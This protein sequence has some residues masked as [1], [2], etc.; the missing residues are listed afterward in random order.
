MWR[1]VEYTSGRQDLAEASLLD[2]EESQL[3]RGCEESA[4]LR[5]LCTP[6]RSGKPRQIISKDQLRSSSLLA[7]WRNTAGIGG[8]V[9][10]S[11]CIIFFKT[12]PMKGIQQSLSSG[13]E[14][15]AYEA[16][17][18]RVDKNHTQYAV[19][20]I[21]W[22]VSGQDDAHRVCL[23]VPY[24][25]TYDGAPVQ[26]WQCNG[27]DMQKFIYPYAYGQIRLYV[28]PQ[29]CLNAPNETISFLHLKECDDEP[30]TGTWP[31]KFILPREPVIHGLGA[32]RLWNL[33]ADPEQT[34]G[35]TQ[36]LKIMTKKMN[37]THLRE[38]KY[39]LQGY[40]TLNNLKN[41]SA[42]NV[43]DLEHNLIKMD[44][45][46]FNQKNKSNPA[47]D[48]SHMA[49]VAWG[50]GGV[51]DDVK[52]VKP[53]MLWKI[54]GD[55]PTYNITLKPDGLKGQY[56]YLSEFWIE[57]KEQK[58]RIDDLYTKFGVKEFQFYLAFEGFSHPPVNRNREV[59]DTWRCKVGPTASYRPVHKK[60][61]MK[62]TEYIRSISGRSWLYL[63]AQGADPTG[64][65]SHLMDG[66][67]KIDQTNV[68]N[69]MAKKL[70]QLYND[71]NEASKSESEYARSCGCMMQSKL[72][73]EGDLKG[74]EDF[75]SMV[76]INSAWAIRIVDQWA[77]FANK[78]GFNGIHW[79]TEG[80]L[81]DPE[82]HAAHTD[83]AGFLKTAVP[84]LQKYNLT[85]TLNF[86]DGY[87]W[88]PRLLLGSW[89][90]IAFKYWEVR[91]DPHDSNFEKH[92]TDD[93]ALDPYGGFVWVCYPGWTQYHCCAHNERQ[94]ADN[95]GKWPIDLGIDRWQ[96][97]TRY[98]GSYLFVGDGKRHVQGPFLPDASFMM[99]KDIK[100]IQAKVGLVEHKLPP[101]ED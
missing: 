20:T 7:T 69:R 37:Y 66:F 93:H 29:W 55:V 3:S 83:I 65:G 31:Q 94:N 40:G 41:E 30:T 101:D 61:I 72:M 51:S 84:Y 64:H 92:L 33:T 68:T 46:S 88:D 91:T 48:R 67:K 19:G 1:N 79:D 23:D 52:L 10:L 99:E 82:D 11:F 15:E 44:H 100:K 74:V 27:K 63:H 81:G 22:A 24:G 87:G 16:T 98:G 14:M 17:G 45:C 39:E 95:Y 32:I 18:K 36:C 96:K 60:T 43:L 89:R 42:D 90:V 47:R 26:V 28:A 50:Q 56:G 70:F 71:Y 4:K 57:E 9:A 77:D 53:D 58:Y 85:Q 35:P 8:L 86:V 13:H 54:E 78:T 6:Q 49:G 73:H 2:V 34:K 25:K 59:K 12:G 38:G 21:Q 62:G 80:D 76:H 97:A 75:V 5:E